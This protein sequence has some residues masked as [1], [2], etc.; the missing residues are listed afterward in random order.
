MQAAYA[1]D[2]P[3]VAELKRDVFA[4]GIAWPALRF[5]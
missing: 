2:Y 5:P 3:D 4:Q 1:A